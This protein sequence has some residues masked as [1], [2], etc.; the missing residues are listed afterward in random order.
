MTF[1]HRPRPASDNRLEAMSDWFELHSKV[2]TGAVVAVA[3]IIGGVW[4]YT[5]SQNLKAERAERAYYSAQQSMAVG[6]M[7][8]AESDLRKMITRYDGTPAAMQA[9]L[10][11]AQLLYDQGKHQEGVTLLKQATPKLEASEEFAASGHLMLATGYEQ[12][13]RFAEAG[14]EY[15]TA[16]K[17]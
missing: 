16:G 4:F 8:L 13:R 15:Q 2:V 10:T 1:P 9:T 7:P 17:K 12:L 14:A 3:V 5:R 11:L 6:N